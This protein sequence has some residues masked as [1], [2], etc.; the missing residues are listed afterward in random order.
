MVHNGRWEIHS[1]STVSDGR[2]TPNEV[3]ELMADH[4]VALWSL[5]DHDHVGGCEE[6]AQA[7][8]RL[9]I[10]F[11]AGIEV[12]AALN[13][14]SIHVLGY[15]VD[16]EVEQLADYGDQMVADR[17]Q[18]MAKMVQRINDLGF[19]VTMDDVREIA[20]GGNLGRPH[21]ARALLKRGHIDN[22]QQAFDR[23]LAD[24]GPGYVP[25]ARP[26][27]PEAAE[28]IRDAGGV[29]VL[30]HPGRYSE[31][32][33][34]LQ[35]WIDAGLWGLEVRHPSHSQADERRLI[36]LAD[37]HGLGKTASNDWHGNKPDS[38]SKLGEVVFPREWKE[39]F[40]EAVG[41]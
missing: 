30:A 2:Y 23:W 22:L 10:E 12:S 37:A 28:M 27:V 5:T 19:E 38:V 15:G 7:A 11:I 17:R 20:G 3:A 14:E 8:S 26:S 40:L 6:A 41:L 25:L 9:G 36:E 4:Q 21:L 39:E 16:T 13:G 1:H 33:A 31:F 29:V 32:S 35:K 34:H 24:D 18:R